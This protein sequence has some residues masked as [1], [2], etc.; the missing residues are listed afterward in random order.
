M[1]A[2]MACS[3]CVSASAWRPPRLS[4]SLIDQLEDEFHRPLDDARG[5]AASASGIEGRAVLP[6]AS[7]VRRVVSGSGGGA[8]GKVRVIEN[9]DPFE[10]DAESQALPQG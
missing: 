8:V 7:G 10:S 2:A 6:E 3:R 5:D 1:A 9:V 4:R